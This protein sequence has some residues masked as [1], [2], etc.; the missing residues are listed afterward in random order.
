MRI[1]AI[2]FDIGGTLLMPLNIP[3]IKWYLLPLMEVEKNIFQELYKQH[4]LEKK[5]TETAF[6]EKVCCKDREKAEK[7]IKRYYSEHPLN[8]VYNDV[9]STLIELKKRGMFLMTISNKSYRNPFFLKTYNLERY[10][11]AEIYSY[12]VNSAKPDDK[13]YKRGQ[14]IAGCKEDE[15]LHIGDSISADVMGAQKLNW[16]TGWISRNSIVNK[17]HKKVEDYF[18]TDLRQIISI[19]S[20]DE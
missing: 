6:Y 4:F 1:K 17:T 15:I 7:I 8:I 9:I 12:Q 14:Y 3:S 11:D 19:V 5:I 18:I 10:F 16:R 13:I 2:S 20:R